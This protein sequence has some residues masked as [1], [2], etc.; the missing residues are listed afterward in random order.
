MIRKWQRRKSS[1]H[2]C[3]TT[4]KTTKEGTLPDII[5]VAVVDKVT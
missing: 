2:L 4:K 3:I 1:L 5:N